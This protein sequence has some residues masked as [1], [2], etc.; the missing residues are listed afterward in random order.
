MLHE[1]QAM[2]KAEEIKHTQAKAMARAYNNA[3]TMQLMK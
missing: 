2:I 3:Q 1:I